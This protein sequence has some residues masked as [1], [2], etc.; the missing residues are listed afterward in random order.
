MIKKQHLPQENVDVAKKGNHYERNWIFFNCGTKQRH[1]D[2][3]FQ[4]KNR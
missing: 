2:Q 1:K 3:P 4:S